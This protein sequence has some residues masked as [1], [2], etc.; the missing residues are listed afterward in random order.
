MS[1]ISIILF[2][3]AILILGTALTRVLGDD[4]SIS[5]IDITIPDLLVVFIAFAYFGWFIFE[6]ALTYI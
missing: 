1:I 6:Y 4:P 5:D 2:I 3:I